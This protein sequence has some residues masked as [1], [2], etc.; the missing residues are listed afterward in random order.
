MNECTVHFPKSIYRKS[1]IEKAISDYSQIC[2][3]TFEIDDIG[4]VCK[5]SNGAVELQRIVDEFCN[6]LIELDHS[7][8]IG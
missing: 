4:Y 8:S 2:T 1:I 3:I 7:W 6:Y 5:F